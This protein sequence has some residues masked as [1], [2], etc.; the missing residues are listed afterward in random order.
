MAKC[1]RPDK[2]VAQ[3]CQAGA[4][5]PHSALALL[6]SHISTHSNLLLPKSAFRPDPGKSYHEVS[7]ARRSEIMNP[8]TAFSDQ[9]S[10]VSFFTVI[11]NP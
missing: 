1:A 8:I 2:G 7:K 11:G 6:P 9:P 4:Y 10:A 3:E 5:N